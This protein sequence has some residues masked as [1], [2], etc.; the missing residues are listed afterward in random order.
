MMFKICPGLCKQLFSPVFVEVLIWHL[1]TCIV[2]DLVQHLV[3][4]ATEL[5]SSIIVAQLICQGDAQKIPE[6]PTIRMH[7]PEITPHEP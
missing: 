3:G 5:L 7:I 2:G 1:V 4:S 6:S